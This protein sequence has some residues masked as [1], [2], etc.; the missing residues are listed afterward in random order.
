[1]KAKPRI[2]PARTAD[3]PALMKLNAYVQDWHADHYPQLFRTETDP[4]GLT[5]AFTAWLEN[6]NARILLSEDG[7]AATG[8]VFTMQSR[9]EENWHSPAYN[10]YE[11]EH[12]VVAP[13]HQSQGHGAALMQAALDAAPEGAQ[14]CLGSW[15]AN[16]GAH[17]FFASFGFTPQLIRFSKD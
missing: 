13:D 1:M 3:I 14:I 6:P 5:A 17:R 10:R 15:A 11:I 2:R 8:Y 4:E 7:D 16:T 12:I 9:H